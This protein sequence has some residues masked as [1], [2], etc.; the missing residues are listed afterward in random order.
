MKAKWRALSP[1]LLGDAPVVPVLPPA[2]EAW[3]RAALSLRE[4]RNVIE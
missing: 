2:P 4:C 3:V 1:E